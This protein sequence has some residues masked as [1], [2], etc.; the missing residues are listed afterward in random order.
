MKNNLNLKEIG[1][2]GTKYILF[3]IIFFINFYYFIML[4]F[5]I[6]GVVLA[7]KH[8]KLS[9]RNLLRVPPKQPIKKYIFILFYIYILIIFK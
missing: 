4:Y 9:A 3:K 5:L 6:L 2:G 1:F 8:R 7:S